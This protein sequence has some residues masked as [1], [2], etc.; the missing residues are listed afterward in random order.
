MR[1]LSLLPSVLAAFCFVGVT[2]AGGGGRGGAFRGG[3]D[4]FD[5]RGGIDSFDGPDGYGDG[6]GNGGGGGGGGRGRYEDDA[7]G[8]DDGYGRGGRG[9]GGGGRGGW[10]DRWRGGGRGGSSGSGS[11]SG[12]SAGSGSEAPKTLMVKVGD[13]ILPPGGQVKFEGTFAI[14]DCPLLCQFLLVPS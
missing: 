1:A 7:Y 11:G 14:S 5:G 9:G 6:Y 8:G 2:N 4:D 3:Y 13:N 12:S 10:R